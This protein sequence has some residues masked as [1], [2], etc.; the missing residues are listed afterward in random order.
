MAELQLKLC[1]LGASRAG[2][3]LLCR[4]LAGQSWS[5]ADYQP[6]AALRIQEIGKSIGSDLVKVQLWD[7]S[8]S[9]SYQQYWE[10]MAKDTDGVI[11]VIDP[12]HPEQEKELEHFYVNFAQ[13]NVLTLKQCMV[14]AVNSHGS[15]SAQWAG[16]RGKLSKLPSGQVDLSKGPDGGA[17]AMHDLFEKVLAGCVVHKKDK[18]ERAVMGD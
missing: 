10:L 4:A 18:M 3:T 17:R 9:N 5:S 13:P 11:L 12:S 16:L 6:T 8:G 1:V 15:S 2:K 14:V 7:L